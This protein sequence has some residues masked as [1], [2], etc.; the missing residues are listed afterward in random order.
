M[1]Q[2]RPFE[3]HTPRFVKAVNY[4]EDLHLDTANLII[5]DLTATLEAPPG[6]YAPIDLRSP[7]EDVQKAQL[8]QGFT[9]AFDVA[10][11][12]LKYPRSKWGETQTF[13]LHVTIW[14]TFSTFSA[15][16]AFFASFFISLFMLE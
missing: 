14:I 15:F 12:E 1:S 9:S 11:A 8:Q 5:Y 7:L 10:L 16:F 6:Q 3:H 4:A 13:K 2:E